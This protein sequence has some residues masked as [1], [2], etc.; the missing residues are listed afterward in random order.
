MDSTEI[1]VGILR[2]VYPSWYPVIGVKALTVSNKKTM[3]S[4]RWPRDRAMRLIYGCP[5]KIGSPW[6]RPNYF[7]WNC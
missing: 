1:L 3:L 7:S 4:Q 2:A 6:V 5:K